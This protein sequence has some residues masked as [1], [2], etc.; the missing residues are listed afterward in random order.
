MTP[1]T[2][3]TRDI[4]ARIR[5]RRGVKP[6]LTLTLDPLIRDSCTYYGWEG[7]EAWPLASQHS[8]APD[9]NYHA[10]ICRQWVQ[11]WAGEG[12]MAPLESGECLTVSIY[13]EE[14]PGGL[15]CSAME[16]EDGDTVIRMQLHGSTIG[17]TDMHAIAQE[18][19]EHLDLIDG[20]P[21]WLVMS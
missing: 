11:R 7:D 3:Q 21:F 9:P 17:E 6:L 15:H 19:L 12:L 10:V 18:L 16:D 2:E 4:L 5:R 14:V 13:G 20:T 8:S 1:M